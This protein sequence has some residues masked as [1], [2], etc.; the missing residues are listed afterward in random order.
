MYL[1]ILLISLAQCDTD[2]PW[3]LLGQSGI[4][5]EIV[6]NSRTGS[7]LFFW[8]FNALNSDISKDR[9]PL[10]MWF[11]G[12]P[13]CSGA[14]GMLGEGISPLY[15]DDNLQPQFNNKT[16]AINYHILMV[17]FPYGSGYSYVT[18]ASDYKNDTVSATNY[19]YNFFQILASKY[20]VWFTNRDWYLFGESYAGHWIPAMAYKIIS[21]NQAANVTGN[22]IIPLKGVGIGDPLADVRYQSQYYAATAFNFGLVNINQQAQVTNTTS[23]IL[24][25]IL[26]GDFVAANNYQN[27]ALALLE[28]F[29]GNVSLYNVRQYSGPD[30]GNYD[31]WMNLASTKTLLRVP[32][33]VTW[34]DCNNDVFNAFSAD[35]ASGIITTMMP[36]VLQSMKVMVYNGQDDLIINT[37]GVEYWFTGINWPYMQNFL[38]ARRGQWMVQGQIAGY[39]I[40]YSNM[41]FVQI[42]K[43]GHLSPFDQPAS[44][45]DMVNRFI[46]NQGWN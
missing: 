31:A 5:G 23:Q 32:S 6:V 28:E 44:V 27:Q 24:A 30:M 2:G 16:W 46:F 20:P 37:L 4:S 39:A 3:T 9:K 19:L 22:T 25:S 34:N 15:I 40:T 12:G 8:Q 33:T 7:S 29:S 18:E 38:R 10:I 14:T 41:T 11:Q 13:G 35:I 21:G 1:V 36:T 43:A 17:D 45:R 26:Q 42:L